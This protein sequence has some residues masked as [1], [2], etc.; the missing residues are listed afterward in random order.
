MLQGDKVNVLVGPDRIAWELPVALLTSQSPFFCKALSGDW[1]EKAEGC[2]HL[3]DLDI[4]TFELAFQY[5][6]PGQIEDA[7]LTAA[8]DPYIS[9]STRVHIRLYGFAEYLQMP[10]LAN[11]S[12]DKISAGLKAEEDT[13]PKDPEGPLV[14]DNAH[15]N[16][17]LGVAETSFIISN[18]PTNAPLY[19]YIVKLWAM[20]RVFD[21]K[22]FSTCFQNSPEFI[23][24]VLHWRI[25]A[26]TFVYC[27]GYDP[28]NKSHTTEDFHYP[29]EGED[30][31]V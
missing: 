14:P 24:S 17:F 30:T 22:K 31:V 27:Y 2:I 12:I 16:G 7:E 23:D 4:P 10:K 5:F 28:R 26:R 1:K 19:E 20:D 6:Y 15:F 13:A 8:E 9:T 25:C 21:D 3:P 11:L 29:V 18:I